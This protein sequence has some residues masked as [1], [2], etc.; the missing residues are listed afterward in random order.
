VLGIDLHPAEF[1]CRTTNHVEPFG[2]EQSG[3]AVE[4]VDLPGITADEYLGQLAVL[5][6]D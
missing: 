3:D 6:F 1:V 5:P 4:Q 2:T